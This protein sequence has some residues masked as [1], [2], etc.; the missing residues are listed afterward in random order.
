M[1]GLSKEQGLEFDVKGRND[2]RYWDKI[3]EFASR[4]AEL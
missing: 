2:L 1:A 3:R 4:F